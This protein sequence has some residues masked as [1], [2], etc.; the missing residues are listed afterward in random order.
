[1]NIDELSPAYVGEERIILKL[2]EVSIAQVFNTLQID[3][4]YA[5]CEPEGVI[6]PLDFIVQGPSEDSYKERVFRRTAPKS[7]SFQP[8]SSGM[9]MIILREQAHNRWIGRLFIDVA[10]DPFEKV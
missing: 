5:D 8:I 7:I 10:G 6:L 1:M 4:D 9:H 2:N 3:V